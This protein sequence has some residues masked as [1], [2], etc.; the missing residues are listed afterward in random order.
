MESIQVGA[1]AAQ[2]VSLDLQAQAGQAIFSTLQRIFLPSSLS[3]F[4][5][6]SNSSAGF[7]L[8]QLCTNPEGWGPVSSER[9]LDFT[10]CFQLA[11]FWTIPTV[12]LLFFG[13]IAIATQYKKPSRNLSKTSKRLLG[14]K[15]T[16]VLGLCKLTTLSLSL[17][18]VTEDHPTRS[19]AFWVAILNL[20]GY[21]FVLPVQ[22]YSHTRTRR[23]SDLLLVFWPLHTLAAAVLIHTSLTPPSPPVKAQVY[24]FVLLCLKT[25]VGL[26]VFGLECAGVEVGGVSKDGAPKW[27]AA[28]ATEPSDALENGAAKK[29]HLG[30]L[31]NL[32]SNG[33]SNGHAHDEEHDAAASRAEE[34]N[35]VN[36]SAITFGDSEDGDAA[37][38]GLDGVATNEDGKRENPENT[39][40]LYSRL[41]FHW[42]QPLFS[43]GR[44]KFLTED[45][46]YALPPTDDCESLGQRFSYHWERTRSKKT[47]KGRIWTTLAWAY[48]GPFA[49]G[50]MFKIAQDLMQFAQPQILRWLLQFVQTWDDPE[51]RQPAELGYLLCI[52][53]FAVATLQTAFLHQYFQ[54]SFN[55][56]LRVRSGLITTIYK[57]SLRLSNDARAGKATGDIVN[58]MSVDASRLQD[59]CTYLHTIWSA[60]FQMTLAFI[61]LG[62]LLGWPAFV[63]IGV[64]IVGIPVNTVIA[65]IT[66]RLSERQMKVRD[67]RTRLMGEILTNIKS[68]KLFAWEDAFTNKLHNVRNER[69]LGLLRKSG[70]INSAFNFLW[71]GIPF[72]VSLATFATYSLV[73]KKDLTPDIIFPA[74]SLFSLLQFP[75]FMVASMISSV[76]QA[77]VSAGRL[78]E[79]LDSPELDPN[80]RKVILPG[81]RRP[82][83][84]R[85]D[86]HPGDPLLAIQDPNSDAREP[87]RGDVVLSVENLEAKWSPSQPVPTLQDVDLTVKK[88]ELLCVLGR[89]GDGK[90]SLLSAILG[91]MHRTDGEVIVRGRTAYFSQGGWCMGASIRDNITFGLKFEPDFYDTVLEACALKADLAILPDGDRTEIGE[92]GVSLSG[93]QRARVALARAVYARADLYLLDDPLAAVDAH[94]GAHIF[95]HV[96]GP[97][98]LLKNRARILTLNTV[99]VLPKADQIISIR[100][101]TI[102]EERGSYDEVMARKGELYTLITGIGKQPS[103]EGNED[104]VDAPETI[105]VEDKDPSYGEDAALA[106]VKPSLRERRIS[107]GSMPR[108]SPLTKRQ[109]KQETIRQLRETSAPA[110]NRER[111][112]VKGEVYKQ[113]LTSAS[114][115]GLFLYMFAQITSYAVQ[116]GR[117]V[118]LKQW[119]A[120]SA[121]PNKPHHSAG[122]W[123]SIYATA[124][125]SSSLL[126]SCAPLILYGWLVI[127]S[128]RK[129]HDNLFHS[130]I[131]SPLQYFEVTP[132]GRLLNLFS[133]DINVI[134]ETLP[135]VIHSAIRTGCVVLGVIIVISYS[136][137]AFIFA[138]IPL[139]IGYWFILQYYLSTSRELKRL[140]SISKSPIFQYFN[141][142]LGGLS[143]IRAFA[144]E[145]RFISTSDSR[146]DRNQECY[147]PTV[148]SNRWL[149]VRIEGIGAT[150]ILL[151]SILAV[152]VKVTSGKMDAGLLGL[153]MSQTLNTTQALNWL[154][155]SFSEVEQNVVSVERV[156]SYSDLQPEAPYEIPETKPAT[157]WPAKGEVRFQNYSSRYRS[158]L[159][160]CLKDL[161]IDIQAGERIGVVG[162]TGA[163][164]SS[165]TLALFRIIEATGGSIFIDGVETNKI[166]LK[167]L[168]QALSIIPQDPQLWEGT[169]RENLDPT[170]KSDDAALWA[171][172]GSAH[173]RE[174]VNSME[175]R[176]DAMLSEGGSNLSAGQRQLVCIARAFLRRSKILVLDEATSAIDL[177][178]DAKLQ[179]IVRSEFTGTTITVAHR[180]NTIMD[181]SRV[182]VLKDGQVEEFDTPENLLANQKSTFF[183]MAYEAGLTKGR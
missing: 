41:T 130:V 15:Q 61:S 149:A 117:D 94:V 48:G 118:V 171:A 99:S 169:L 174:H 56:G 102:M 97:T 181:S 8:S 121:D 134:D 68:I 122:F 42:M 45:D 147:L 132:S 107:T 59:L 160:L 5:A 21:A 95:E 93:G 127:S 69:E 81:Q 150:T 46:M 39:A 19:L 120:E 157:G 112:R 63:G 9:E 76:I 90:S 178:T 73:T 162:R 152:F 3:T 38:P 153:M 119:G 133:R 143:V 71:T 123:L 148:T 20:V 32:F 30:K 86:A 58:L 13:S 27:T 35:G 165:L 51:K 65:R 89:V 98:G 182:L 16:F 136:V 103:R 28:G 177:A 154:V 108:P 163:G 43:L 158:N 12:A 155:R 14:L 172:L 170:M 159:P 140:D 101:G 54:R 96:I 116:I 138:I 57:K 146:V 25:A 83:G 50:G 85:N 105:E 11:T 79:F 168:R 161:K 31:Y 10:P 175:G 24:S 18:Y 125:Y 67:A 60:F 84:G 78:A 110:E 37:V 131:R 92:R 151:A 179:Q 135:R 141:E 144:Q 47:G 88:G 66:R 145:N 167:D 115:F 80:A 72:T 87:E 70:V 4:A 111:G 156:L 106:D 55:T 176:L 129:F 100:R 164:K 82:T 1:A 173:L 74:L 52:L 75:L 23:S 44:K 22:H 183:S 113:Y 128:A 77:Q 180:L 142:T 17:T 29:S 34:T 104:T 26:V 40:N 137:P 124:G 91:E 166:G 6:N 109:V 33:H 7:H 64:M 49:V 139:G 53:L 2:P 126:M 62:Y 36:E 114:G